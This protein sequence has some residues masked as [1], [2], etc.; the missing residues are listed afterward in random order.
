[1]RRRRFL[2]RAV[3]LRDWL[4]PVDLVDLDHDNGLMADP[5]KNEKKDVPSVGLIG[6]LNALY[7]H[8]LRIARR[9][10]AWVE[11]NLEAD[12][13]MPLVAAALRI[14]I[15]QQEGDSQQI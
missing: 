15:A 4:Y 11:D 1:M 10:L 2:G 7:G 12:P 6:G 13:T 5:S 8:D 9:E 14:V 3:G